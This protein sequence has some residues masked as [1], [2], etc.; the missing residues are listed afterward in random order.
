MRA[1]VRRWI[2]EW[3]LKRLFPDV[4]VS[5]EERELGASYVED[6]EL[7]AASELPNKD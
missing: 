4:A 3:D 5:M 1:H 6:R 2:N 7:E